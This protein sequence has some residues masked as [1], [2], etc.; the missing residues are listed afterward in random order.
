MNPT[1]VQLGEDEQGE[2][3][4][5]WRCSKCSSLHPQHC[6]A[7]MCCWR[8]PL[9][10]CGADLPPPVSTS[11]YNVRHF[12]ECH[13]CADLHLLYRH[14]LA[15]KDLP[16]VVNPDVS[17]F[18]C[19]W[20]PC[21]DGDPINTDYLLDQY[22]VDCDED[23]EK[24]LR[25]PWAWLCKPYKVELDVDRMLEDALDEAADETE[26]SDEAVE[27]LRSFIE[28]WNL[29]YSQ[30]NYTPDYGRIVLVSSAAYGNLLADATA[31]DAARKEKK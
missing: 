7:R 29:K 13:R 11:M 4:L 22:E 2:P 25:S 23:T 9:C 20:S 10:A 1:I 31:W 14:T 21:A 5:H 15:T 18:P 19:C 24:G 6:D 3:V 17:V 12:T 30:T 16:W 28:N 26:F 27:E 8:K